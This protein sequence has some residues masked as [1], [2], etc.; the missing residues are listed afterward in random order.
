LP[1]PDP[2]RV[3]DRGPDGISNRDRD[4][5]RDRDRNRDR[6]R[7]SD[8]SPADPGPVGRGRHVGPD[9]HSSPGG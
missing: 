5:D 9:R 2:D 7:V 6:D 8:A 1:D 3:S 4:R